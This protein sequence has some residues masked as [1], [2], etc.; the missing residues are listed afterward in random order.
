MKKAEVSGSSMAMPMRTRLPG[1]LAGGDVQ[2]RAQG[3]V[4]PIELGGLA[5]GQEGTDGLAGQLQDDFAGSGA[6]NSMARMP[7]S[8]SMASSSAVA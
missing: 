8:N 4:V 1:A 7:F 3:L 5:G 2:A 6:A